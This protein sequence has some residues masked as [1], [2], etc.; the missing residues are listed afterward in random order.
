MTIHES[1]RKAS[2]EF[3]ALEQ[4]CSGSVRRNESLKRWTTFRCEAKADAI[5]SPKTIEMLTKLV[6]RLIAMKTTWRVLGRGS[7]LLVKD[8]GYP[9]ALVDLAVGFSAIAIENEDSRETRV[10]VEGGV[11]NGTFLQWCR[12]RNLKGFG[13]S[14]GIPG[15]IGG[16]IRMNAGTPLG[17]FSQIL[18]EV[19]GLDF[20]R[21]VA[22]PTQLRV[23]EKDF[24]YRDFPKGHHL[25]ITAGSFCLKK[26]DSASVNGEIEAAKD[27]RKNQPL[28]LPNFGSVF[29]NPQGDFAGRLIEAAGLKGTRI[30]DAEISRRHANF[31]VNLGRAKTA[32]A[33]TLMSMAQETVQEKF[34]VKLEPEVHVIGVEA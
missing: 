19:E 22:H 12:D 1:P 6:D 23:E 21:K 18:R 17:S 28:E 20:S 25:V 4:I 16:G 31:I 13:F 24:L 10:R 29:K 34:G 26:S 2:S 5:A 14:F 33:L 8:G 30:G 9:G 27:R 3:D 11:A 15:S 32:D 7:N